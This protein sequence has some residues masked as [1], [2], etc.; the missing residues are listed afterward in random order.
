MSERFGVMFDA[1]PLSQ[2]GPGS[3]FMREFE[4]VKRSFGANEDMSTRE[5]SPLTMKIEDSEYYD[6]EERAVLLS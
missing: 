5:I 1:V 2:K 6:L 4:K 3:R